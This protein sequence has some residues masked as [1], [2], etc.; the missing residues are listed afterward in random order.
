MW[1]CNLWYQTDAAVFKIFMSDQGACSF[2]MFIMVKLSLNCTHNLIILI[3]FF[4]F[5]GVVFFIL[6][7][8]FNILMGILSF[9]VF[10]VF[11]VQ[12]NDCV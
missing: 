9:R 12:R 3:L 10:M 2:S 6:M 5:V 1:V 7:F 8:I 11:E 4:K